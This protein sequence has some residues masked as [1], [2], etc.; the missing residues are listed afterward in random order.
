MFYLGQ[1]SFHEEREKNTYYGFFNCIVEAENLEKAVD[2][3]NKLLKSTRKSDDLFDGAI[4]IFLDEIFEIER[5]P[6]DGVLTTYM[7]IRGDMPAMLR[8]SIFN[9]APGIQC[10]GWTEDQDLEEEKEKASKDAVAQL[11]FLKFAEKA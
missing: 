5:I 4:S 3:F 9:E 10:Y 8:C 11:P 7:S 6:K 2:L 1:F